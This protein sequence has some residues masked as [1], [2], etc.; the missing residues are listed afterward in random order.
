MAMDNNSNNNATEK[1]E[2]IMNKILQTISGSFAPILGVLA[3]SALITAL[4]SLLKTLGWISPESGTYA[5]LSAAG[6]AIFYFFPVFLGIT[7][8]IKLGANGYVG[9]A[10]GASLLEPNYT[11]L[12]TQGAQDVSFLGIPVILA[13]YSSTVFP[14]LIAVSIY[15]LLDRFLKKV[16]YK[17]LQMF[18]NPMISLLVIVPLTILIFG[19]FGTYVGEALSMAIQFLSSK[20]GLLTGAVLGAGWSFLTILG[21]HWAVI[22]ISIANLAATGFDPIIP[23]AA[24]APFAQIGLGLGV[25][26]KTK[27]KD[28]RTLAG[29]G[30]LP[31]ALAGTT[32]IITYGILVPYKRTML[33]VAIAGAVGGGIIG[34]LGVKGTG[35]ALPSLLSI[36]VFT[37]MSQFIIGTLVA[38]ILTMILVLLFGYEGKNVVKPAKTVK[39]FGL[40]PV[41]K[42]T[43]SS[44]LN[45]KIISLSAIDDPLFSSGTIGKG[46]AI[47]PTTG[48]VVSPVDGMVTS[49]FASNHAIGITSDDGAEILIFIGVNTVQ[50]KG[51]FFTSHVKQWD[52]VKKGDLL[53]EFD[54]ENIK[55]A[56]YDVKT[57]VVITN[58]NQY[59]DVIPTREG[60][61]QA[62]EDIIK[63]N[64]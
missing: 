61:V 52:T 47:E 9:G 44:P 3:G 1:K 23:M 64:V 58:T 30:L 55:A 29:S 49:L 33:Y 60:T 18:I 21:L 14:I 4:L 10:I 53:I 25:F 28:L 46:I 34:T 42:E 35:F 59:L 63:L 56:G 15:T 16:I 12:L 43:I 51:Q 50:L 17:D 45:G 5:I 62:Q 8:A 20:S 38:L 54:I 48:K 22:P 40:G 36:P 27:D 6:H 37:P 31:S 11:N 24:A 26:F 57:P 39:E 13:N 2:T 32:E 19:P 7:M 41:T